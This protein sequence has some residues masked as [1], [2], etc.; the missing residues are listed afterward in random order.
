LKPLEV[1]RRSL[2]SQVVEDDDVDALGQELVRDVATE[3]SAAAG[4]EVFHG[5]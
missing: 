1:F 4:D 2:T 5:V 3:E